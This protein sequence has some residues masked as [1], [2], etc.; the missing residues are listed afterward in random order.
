MSESHR[1]SRLNVLLAL[2]LVALVAGAVPV[3]APASRGEKSSGTS[4]WRAASA[5]PLAPR[6]DLDLR[7]FP[8]L[9]AAAP[10]LL[11]VVTLVRADAPRPPRTVVPVPPAQRSPLP[12]APP[13]A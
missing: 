7:G 3:R 10:E 13:A 9:P 6:P 8:P 11:P 2:L 1:R 5:R 12:R 4:A